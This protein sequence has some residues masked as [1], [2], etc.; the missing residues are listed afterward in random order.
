MTSIKLNIVSPPIAK[1]RTLESVDYIISTNGIFNSDDI[2]KEELKDIVN[3][4]GRTF[5]L[6][7]DIQDV[8]YARI[9]LN[10]VDKDNK[11]SRL[12]YRTLVVTKN[13]DG[14]SHNNTVIVTP[15]VNIENASNLGLGGFDI[16][17]SEFVSYSGSGSHK[18]T[19]FR[20]VSTSGKI[21]WERVR[22]EYNLT[23]I[24]V[25][26]NVLDSNRHYIVE[27]IYFSNSNQPSNAGKTIIKTLG[28]SHLVTKVK[29]SSA[30]NNSEDYVELESAYLELLSIITNHL[31]L[32]KTIDGIS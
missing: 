2:V 32:G 9:V 8:Y 27:V 12:I 6:D 21:M 18:S 30:I 19:T 10:L 5:E 24:R 23:G 17:G 4:T 29:A 28:K 15:T 13:G 16:K 31:A 26:D 14:F 7:F 11:K 22:D 3:L 20:V 25:P 1:D